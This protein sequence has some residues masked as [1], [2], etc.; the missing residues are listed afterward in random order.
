MFY[1]Y[2]YEYI[3]H[4]E[5]KHS[6]STYC[7]NSSHALE[8]DLR[9]QSAFC[10]KSGQRVKFAMRGGSLCKI[11]QFLRPIYVSIIIQTSIRFKY[12]SATCARFDGSRRFVNAMWC[13]AVEPLFSSVRTAYVTYTMHTW[14]ALFARYTFERPTCN[15]RCIP[16][17]CLVHVSTDHYFDFY[18]FVARSYMFFCFAPFLCAY[19]G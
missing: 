12:L 11:A 2:T 6:T 18:V 3:C 17:M 1:I 10:I 9:I 15:I 16:Y 5:V 8:Y 4:S 14:I 13:S 19:S 7:R